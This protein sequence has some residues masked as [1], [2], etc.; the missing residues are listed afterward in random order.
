MSDGS[1]RT[2]FDVMK[3]LALGADVALIGR[4][5]ARM[6]LIG[7]SEAVRMYLDYARAAPG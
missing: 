7:G 2:G 4:P 5:L 6:C 1:V 3:L